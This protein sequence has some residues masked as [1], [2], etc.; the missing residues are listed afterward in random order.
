MICM[1]F[2]GEIFRELIL[3]LIVYFVFIFRFYGGVVGFLEDLEV[4]NLL[5]EWV[6]E[7]F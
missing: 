5:I 4:L 1:K 7:I 3:F 2:L 6:V